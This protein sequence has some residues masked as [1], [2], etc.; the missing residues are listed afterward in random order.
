[1]QLHWNWPALVTG[2]LLIKILHVVPTYLPATRYGGPIHSVHGLCKALVQQGHEVHVYTTNVDGPGVSDVPLGRPVDIDGVRV[3]YF[4]SSFPRRLYRSP[5]MGKALD[6][7]LDDFDLLHIHAM[8]LWPGMAASRA[9]WKHCIPYL[10]SPRGMLVPE[11]IARKSR[12]AKTA[13][14]RLFDR[15]MVRRASAIHVTST[16]EASDLTAVGLDAKRVINIPNGIDV[17]D[18]SSD[19]PIERENFIL[20]L[21][22]LDPKKSVEL[23]IKAVE[24]VPDAQL[25]IAGDGEPDYLQTLKSIVERSGMKDRITFLGHLDNAQKWQY[26]R[27]AGVFVLPSL[28]ENFANTVLEAMAAGC[29]VVVTPGVGLADTVA[30]H[31]CGGVVERD[32]D[33]IAGAITELLGNAVLRKQLGTNGKALVEREFSWAVLADSYNSAYH[34]CLQSSNMSATEST[35]NT[36]N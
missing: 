28:S 25:I 3:T 36:C 6:R 30:R 12:L 35:R 20:F 7:N 11:L 14:I 10:V 19:P 5:E 16:L 2:I 1:L 21:G 26:Y 23:L 13:W 27:R 8:F 9:A 18:W 15:S 31:D 29:P 17:P 34:S 24:Q 32:A 22:R 33:S 4:S